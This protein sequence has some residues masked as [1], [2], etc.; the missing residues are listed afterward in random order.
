MRGMRRIRLLDVIKAIYLA[1]I[2]ICNTDCYISQDLC[3]M[4]NSQNR[5]PAGISYNTLCIL[6]IL[7]HILGIYFIC[8]REQNICVVYTPF[9]FIYD[10]FIRSSSICNAGREQTT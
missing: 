1:Q 6:E 4:L 10:S 2:E 3:P 5:L 9:C 7:E 8:C